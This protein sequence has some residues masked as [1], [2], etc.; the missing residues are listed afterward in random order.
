M[1]MKL[2]FLMMCAFVFSLSAGVRA[3][4]QMV[5]LNV[6]G[7]PFT[8]VISELKRQTQLDFFYSFDEVDVKQTISLNVKNTKIDEVLQ[9]ILGGK[10]TWEYIDR[11][12]IIKP[13]IPDEPE[14]KSLR[15]KGFVYD[16]QRV[17]M[18]GVTVKVA[19]VSL[20]TATNSQGWF[21]MDLPVTSGTLEFSFVGF[22]K[23]TVTFNTQTDT[24]RIVLEEDIQ[25][26]DETIVVAYGETTRRKS[27]GSVS[28]V[29]ADEM[30]GIPSSSIAS[31]LQGRVAGM[32]ITQMSG[33]P[34]GGGTAVIIRGYNSLDVEQGRRF[35]DPLWVV[36]GVPMNSFTSPISGTNLLSDLNPEMIE[37]VQVLKDA[38]AAS[39][40]GSRAANGVILVTTKKGKKNQK[41]NFAVNFSQT[42][43]ILPKLPD[44]TIGR[45]ERWLRLKQAKNNV[46]AYLD[47]KT[48]QYKYPESLREQYENSSQSAV[49]DKNFVA[50]SSTYPG[51]TLQDSLNP[52]YNNATNYFPVYYVKGKVT[53]ANIQT[54]GGGE[55]MSYGLG[56]GYYKEDGVFRGTGYNRVDLNSSM[57][58][59]PVKNLNVDMRFNASLANRK[60]ATKSEILGSSAPSV[61]VVP[62][63]PL[64]L[65]S[66]LPGEGSVPWNAVLEA[67]EGTKEKNRNIRLRT[68]FRVGYQPVVGLDITAM[69]AA[70]YSIDRRNY[71]QPSYLSDDGFSKSM[72][73]TGVNLMVLN[74]NLVSYKRTIKEDHS[75]SF[76]GGFSYQ[77]DQTEYNGGSAQNS[78]SDKIYYAPDGL[79]V[80]GNVSTPN[81]GGG[82]YEKPVAF[83]RYVSDMQEKSLIS[84]FARLEYDFRGKYMLSASF[85]RD[86]SSTFG[87]DNRWG[88]FPSVAAAWTFTEENWVKDN[89][90]WLSFGKLRASW[91]RSGMHFSQCY[92]A[93]GELV[94][95][96]VVHGDAYVSAFPDGG[97]Y[98]PALSWEETDQYDFG[99]DVDLFNYRLTVTA[100]YYY[101]Y[102]DK[103]L[104]KIPLEGSHNGYVSQ[105][106]NAMAISNEGMEIMIKYDI[107]R[108]KDLY[109]KISVNGAKNWNRFQKSYNGR[110]YAG[111]IIGKPLNGIYAFLTDGF[112]DSY[113]DL[114]LYH[115]AAGMGYYVVKNE[116]FKNYMIK[117]GDINYVDVNGDGVIDGNDQVYMGSTLPEISGGIVNELRWK[118]FDLNMLLSYSIGRHA[119]NNL[120][121]GSIEGR[122]VTP[123]IFNPD[124][125]S[126]W[127]KPGDKAD[128]AAVGRELWG[129]V[130]YNVEKVNYLRL[131]SLTVGYS[132]PRRWLQKMGM[133]ELRL[134]VSGENLLTWTNYSGLD[135][136]TID[137]TSGG[138][139]NR[140]YPLARKYT[141]GIT[142][143][144]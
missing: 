17:P 86:G 19:G 78:P 119:V 112:V 129:L 2:T 9:Q 73:E 20:G 95:A 57:N 50:V 5:T 51:T 11:M 21:A 59:I 84:Y 105:W 39:I 144:F 47:P 132:L 26:L 44:V 98:N 12:V 92:L 111:R 136:E 37:S 114:K 126:F 97:M 13:A 28:V 7:M 109:W 25:A 18:P 113:D 3:Q 96:G 131:K 93:L 89:L 6:E 43:S 40:Y 52:F 45:A 100:D 140:N 110:D 69:L 83:Q 76:V 141:L 82:T 115:N 71:F 65:N 94:L 99:L 8:K 101:R 54:Y 123:L 124:K 143:K 75:V 133:A 67:Y 102:T 32:D 81:I 116:V 107:F 23:K 135:P 88:T 35:S 38:S 127:E 41:A 34:G 10:F 72:G 91:G 134:F 79:P 4:D 125:I 68:N 80:L 77:Y 87:A 90:G 63:E 128:Y 137:L 118:N 120:V 24:L 130:D 29:K 1:I 64:E 117:E 122:S 14:K 56:L 66:F 138:D 16:M 36:D 55:N 108:E 30:K 58:V 60:R 31:L 103:M 70:D 27:T 42:W 22:K 121:S 74:E 62:G 15:V 48:N 33:S 104:A 106:Q 49:Y 139:Q 61:E 46:F 53:N 142:L 85:R